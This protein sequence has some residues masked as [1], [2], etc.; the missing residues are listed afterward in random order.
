MIAVCMQRFRDVFEGL[1][2]F[3]RRC[4][5]SDQF[6]AGGNHTL[7]L[8]YG[9][10]HVEGISRGHGLNA[11]GCISTQRKVSNGNF[12]RR[13]SAVIEPIDLI[14]GGVGG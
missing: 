10:L 1:R 2:F 4:G 11:N 7:T 12:S 14:Q 5:Y 6:T 8:R 3:S 13:P 9:F